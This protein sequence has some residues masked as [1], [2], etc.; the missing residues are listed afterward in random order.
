MRQLE[1]I[2]IGITGACNMR[3]LHCSAAAYNC[4]QRR[5]DFSLREIE[6]IITEAKD[7]GAQEIDITGGEPTLRPDLCRIVSAA[8]SAVLKVKLLSN[9]TLLDGEKLLKLKDV[10][11]SGLAVS[12]DGSSNAIQSKIRATTDAEFQ[13]T[14][15]TIGAATKLGIPAKINT[16]AS[17]VNLADLHNISKLAAGLGCYEHRICLFLP[18]GRGRNWAGNFLEPQAWI[19]FAAANFGEL[20]AGIKIYIAT[21]LLPE[22][23]VGRCR[24]DCAIG[25][26]ATL[27]IAPDGNV[28]PCAIFAFNNLPIGNVREKNLAEIWSNEKI[29]HE[30]R[31][32]AKRICRTGDRENGSVFVCPCRKI[33]VSIFSNT[34]ET[35]LNCSGR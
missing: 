8:D 18:V 35:T 29:W 17:A 1:K 16:V 14:I 15:A 23:L 22:V 21:I 31:R 11:L 7:L 6:K 9:G 20:A 33:D 2:E 30:A 24:T 34:D 3:C 13:N 4:P 28:F 32:L 26:P 12:V 19:R 10:G 5:R 27:S 25:D